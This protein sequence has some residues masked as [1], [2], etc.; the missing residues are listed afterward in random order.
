MRTLAA[1]T[2]AIFSIT[3]SACANDNNP[4]PDE[5]Q[6]RVID[7]SILHVI[8]Q[9]E[10]ADGRTVQL[11]G[12]LAGEDNTYL[13]LTKEYAQMRDTLSAVPVE[14]AIAWEETDCLNKYVSMVGAYGPVSLGRHG[15]HKVFRV[16]PSTDG[17]SVES[18][19][20]DDIP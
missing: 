1:T 19:F 2:L 20:F 8:L 3:A 15:F 17:I 6:P 18:C 5:P 13:F 11:S 9:P 10:F 12:F 4:D 16:F 7:V 14:A